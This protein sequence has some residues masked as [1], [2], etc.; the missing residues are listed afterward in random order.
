MTEI[1]RVPLHPIAKGSLAKLWLGIL[2]AIVFGAGLAW[3]AM[4]QGADLESNT[5]SGDIR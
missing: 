3:A 1:T 5:F 4:P 2:A